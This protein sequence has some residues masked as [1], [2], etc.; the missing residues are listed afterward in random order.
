MADVDVHQH[1]QR[2][3]SGHGPD[4]LR[5]N[6]GVGRVVALLIDHGGGREDHDQPRDY[7]HQVVK[8]SH[9]STPTRFAI[10]SYGFFRAF[11]SRRS[12]TSCLKMRPRCS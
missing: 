11:H 2:Q 12:H 8:N 7:Q 6:E 5:K 10:R 3:H 9:L 4:G 1:E